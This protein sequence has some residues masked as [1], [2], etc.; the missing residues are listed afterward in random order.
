MTLRRQGSYIKVIFFYRI[1]F[2][3][4]KKL[5]ANL[6]EIQPKR[7]A[8]FQPYLSDDFHYFLDFNYFRNFQNSNFLGFASF[9]LR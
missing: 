9:L 8:V 5:P 7:Q 3:Q 4:L 1:L 2:F 6:K